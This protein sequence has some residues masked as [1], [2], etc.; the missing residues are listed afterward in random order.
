MILSVRDSAQVW[1][2]S[3]ADTIGQ[4]MIDDWFAKKPYKWISRCR[5]VRVLP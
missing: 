1:A 4:F 5:E 2:N 3:F